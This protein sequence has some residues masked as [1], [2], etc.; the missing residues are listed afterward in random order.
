MFLYTY[1][2]ANVKVRSNVWLYRR[3]HSFWT[4]ESTMGG[5]QITFLYISALGLSLEMNDWL[6]PRTCSFACVA[7]RDGAREVC[8]SLVYYDSMFLHSKKQEVF[9]AVFRFTSDFCF[10]PV[11]LKFCFRHI[12]SSF[13]LVFTVFPNCHTPQ[14]AALRPFGAQ[15]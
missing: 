11:K 9:H 14:F 1:G 3:S 10:P 12:C 4:S 2:I 5:W 15:L 7:R 13:L 6:L 8:L